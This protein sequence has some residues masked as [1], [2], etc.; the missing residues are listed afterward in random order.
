MPSSLPPYLRIE[1]AL[2]EFVLATATQ[3]QSHIKPLHK[4]VALRL[5]IEGGFLPQ[6]VTPRPPLVYER[7]NTSHSITFDN[8]EESSSERAIVG[9]VKSKNVDVV[10]NKDGIGPVVAVSIKGTGNAFR[11]LTNRMEEVIGDCANLHMMYPGLVYGFLHVIKANCAGQP[12]VGPNDICIDSTGS[13]VNSI[14]RWHNVLAELTGR[15]MLSNDVMRYESIALILAETIENS[16]GNISRG[17]PA[18]GSPLLLDSFFKV[19][20]SLYDLRFSYKMA[21]SITAR[22]LEWDVNSKALTDLSL[23]FGADLPATLGY[24][25]RA[26]DD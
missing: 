6:D 22:R 25:P 4:Y 24:S 19:L 14:N 12:N 3:D 17:F 15:R 10:V 7:R 9:G 26:S 11:N 20:Y 13:V 5:V 23:E 21:Q 2:R 18:V 1:S 8:S 16:I